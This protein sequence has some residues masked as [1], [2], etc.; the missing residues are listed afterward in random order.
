MSYGT[1]LLEVPRCRVIPSTKTA[2]VRCIALEPQQNGLA[3]CPSRAA[4]SLR[5]PS[6]QQGRPCG[7]DPPR[8]LLFARGTPVA[9]RLVTGCSHEFSPG[10]IAAIG[11]AAAG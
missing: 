7:S 10:D 2:R 8:M 5:P 3:F 4:N 6:S 9:M 1:S 11:V